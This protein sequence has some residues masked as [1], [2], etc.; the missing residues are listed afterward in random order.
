MVYTKTKDTYD[1]FL[2]GKMADKTVTL[3]KTYKPCGGSPED[4]VK[5]YVLGIGSPY[6]IVKV[7]S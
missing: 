5:V 2:K 7:Y 1:E 4:T 6:N 3:F